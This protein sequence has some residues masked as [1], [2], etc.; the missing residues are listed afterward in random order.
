MPGRPLPA[1]PEYRPAYP[2]LPSLRPPGRNPFLETLEIDPLG[3]QPG[4][5]ETPEGTA[6][7]PPVALPDL[8]IRGAPGAG[9]NVPVPPRDQ[10]AIGAPVSGAEPT[11]AQRQSA[12]DRAGLP[13]ATGGA[14]ESYQTVEPAEAAALARPDAGGSMASQPHGTPVETTAIDHPPPGATPPSLAEQV[15]RYEE[16]NPYFTRTLQRL[17]AG[18]LTWQSGF[19]ATR[20]VRAAFLLNAIQSMKDGRPLLDITQPDDYLNFYELRTWDAAGDDEQVGIERSLT[21]RFGVAVGELVEFIKNIKGIP[22]HPAAEAAVQAKSADEFWEH[23]MV[24]PLG[25]I[26]QLSVE[27]LVATLSIGLLAAAGGAAGG[28]LGAGFAM[29]GGSLLTEHSQSLIEG[30][31]RK[32]VDISDPAV[33]KKALGDRAL[34]EDLLDYAANRAVVIGLTDAVLPSRAVPRRLRDKA[35]GEFAHRAVEATA[36]DPTLAAGGEALAQAVTEG[37][38]EAGPVLGE[39]VA[40]VGKVAGAP[41]EAAAAHAANKAHKGEAVEPTGPEPP[42][43]L[44]P[45]PELATRDLRAFH[46]AREAASDARMEQTFADA[47]AR[48]QHLDKYMTMIT[49]MDFIQEV[50]KFIADW[51]IHRRDRALLNQARQQDTWNNL[52]AL[53]RLA[54]DALT[55]KRNQIAR[56]AVAAFEA[57]RDDEGG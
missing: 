38:V 33:V 39:A 16:E 34:M 8:R 27:N 25:V 37:R 14:P 53:K 9:T 2:P 47:E 51:S 29:G 49:G 12:I 10:V 50:R 19:S 57:R 32:G 56:D 17:T 24:D 13:V 15:R 43:P 18:W 44:A 35:I 1:P 21:N 40:S 42:P 7:A 46:R 31:Q 30:L 22:R 45:E 36:V 11:E 48:M 4:A 3:G 5:L 23:F 28:A 41:V 55:E 26:G 6:I 52:D 54:Q 20:A